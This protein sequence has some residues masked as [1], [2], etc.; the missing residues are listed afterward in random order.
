MTNNF[1]FQILHIILLYIKRFYVI[2]N[3]I[4]EF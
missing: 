1:Y 2:V 4:V 3:I